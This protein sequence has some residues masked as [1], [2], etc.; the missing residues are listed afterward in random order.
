RIDGLRPVERACCIRQLAGAM[1]ERALAAA[2]AAEIET[3]Y[4][5][6]AM[7]ERV[8]ALI[9]DLVVHRAVELRMRM[10]DHRN[11]RVL[12]FRRMVAAFKTDCGTG[13]D[14]FRHQ[15]ISVDRFMCQPDLK[16]SVDKT[17]NGAVGLGAEG[18]R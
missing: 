3:Q 17:A 5:E 10:Q 2:D 6:A 11:R 18:A 9:D 8:V 4:R 16:G 14:D 12:L 1:I 7:R 13:E 15:L